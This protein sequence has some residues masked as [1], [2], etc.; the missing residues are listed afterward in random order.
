MAAN[1][2]ALSPM[3]AASNQGLLRSQPKGTRW[4]TSNNRTIANASSS[5]LGKGM[6]VAA[7]LLRSSAPSSAPATT[8]AAMR[9]ARSTRT[10]ASARKSAAKKNN[11]VTATGVTSAALSGVK[12]D[13]KSEMIRSPTIPASAPA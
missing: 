3:L 9:C 12:S 2:A 8:S 1:A 13:K 7:P 5:T 10:A 4:P 11:A 6:M